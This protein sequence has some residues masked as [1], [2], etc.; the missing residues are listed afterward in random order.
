M[1]T[2]VFVAIDQI[3]R[4][5]GD[6]NCLAS[7]RLD[8]A[9]GTTAQPTYL[10]TSLLALTSCSH[11]LALSVCATVLA[12]TRDRTDVTVPVTWRPCSADSYAMFALVKC[13]CCCH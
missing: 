5:A 4:I 12:F 7:T 8:V 3:R 6:E 1:S 2:V 10:N 9:S 13:A 11:E